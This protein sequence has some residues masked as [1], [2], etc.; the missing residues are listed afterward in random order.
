MIIWK[1]A[2]SWSQRDSKEARATPGTWEANVGSFRLV[3][4]RH[5]HH[6]PDAWIMKIYPFGTICVA[7]SKDIDAAKAEAIRLLRSICK[8]ALDDIGKEP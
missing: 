1:D 2:T 3:V 6:S 4:T 7:K 5:I 8:V